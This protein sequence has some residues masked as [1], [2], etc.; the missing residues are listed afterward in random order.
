M[1]WIADDPSAT[2]RTE[3]QQVLADAM[4]GKASALAE[5]TE[6]MSAPLTFGT[7]GLRGPL[8]AGPAGMNLA[9][10]R[11]AAAGIAAYLRA[12]GGPGR[13]VVIGYD[14]RHRSAEFAG[15]AAKVLAAAG[16]T[17]LLAPGPLPTPITAYAVRELNAAAGLQITA[18][19]NPPQDNG[20]KVYLEAGAQL[21]P[22]A[23]AAIEAA[24]AAAR[25]AVSIDTDGVPQPWPDSIVENYLH[26]AAALASGSERQLRIVATAMHGVGASTLLEALRRA[27]FTDVHQVPAQEQPDPA[28]PTVAFP[29][30]EEPGATDQ[31]L[32]LATELDADLAIANDPDADRCALGA[33]AADGSWRMLRGDE[34]GALLGD[35]LLAGLNPAVHPDPLVA[36]TIVSSSLLKSIAAARS[37]RFDE[38]LTGF[39]W[40]VRAGDG[41]GTGLVYAYEEALG[42]CVDPDGVRDK[43]GISAGVVAADLAATLKAAGRTVFDALDD[44]ARAHGLHATDQLSV[45][46]SDLTEIADA[47]ARLRAALPSTLLGDPVTGTEDLLPRTDAVV[48]R[49]DRARVVVRPSGTEPKL[50]C[51]LEVTLP[52]A[53]GLAEL[54]GVRTDAAEQLSALRSELSGLLGL[55]G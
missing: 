46:V 44:L 48:L 37:A 2:D 20:L 9:V 6:R 14:A 24:I 21:V 16:F 10:V 25:P 26:R 30:P 12:N 52:V 23:D 17:V 54:T 31:L 53:A 28:F 11:R 5:L 45:R 49:T 43:D 47:M 33:K 3:L 32:A 4:G 19:H 42:V 7:A 55:S 29:N 22:P 18:S 50:K 1:R 39:K 36:T 15:D 27:G 40:L 38:T 51:Y 41:R 35:H 34:T 13:T 8:R